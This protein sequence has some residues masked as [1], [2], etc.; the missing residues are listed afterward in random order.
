MEKV[1][2]AGYALNAIFTFG[3]LFVTNPLQLFI[4]QAGL[5]IAEAIG[6]PAWDTLYAKNIS[7]NMDSYAWGLSTG[8]SQI[9]TGL[10]FAF[11]GLITNF[12]SF[13]ALF[14]TMGVIQIIAAIVSSQLIFAKK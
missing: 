1:L 6:T 12:I 13:D 7:E 8:Q 3:Y 11:G 10:A 2:V 14:V 5:G 9:V 4:V